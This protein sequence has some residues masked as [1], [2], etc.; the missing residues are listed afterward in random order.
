MIYLRREPAG[1]ISEE[2]E[3]RTDEAIS[4]VLKTEEK[5]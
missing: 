2:K 1:K 3:N 4:K 5:L